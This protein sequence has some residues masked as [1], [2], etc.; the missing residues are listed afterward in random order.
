[1]ST[2]TYSAEQLSRTFFNS[3]ATPAQLNI[4]VALAVLQKFNE[5]QQ[6]V[7]LVNGTTPVL[8]H[9]LNI[10]AAFNHPGV[11]RGLLEI[12]FK[13]IDL[14]VDVN[15]PFNNDPPLMF[16]ALTFRELHLTKVLIMKTDFE[17]L[18]NAKSSWLTYFLNNL[19]TIPGEPVPLTKLLLHADTIVRSKPDG[20]NAFGGID[21]IK[22]L[23]A[24]ATLGGSA[25]PTVKVTELAT[26]SA[27]YN[28][29]LSRLGKEGNTV[30]L[31]DMVLML[32]EITSNVHKVFL[33]RLNMTLCHHDAPLVDDKKASLAIDEELLEVY[34][35]I[36]ARTDTDKV[37]GR[38][39]LHGLCLSGSV[40][41]LDD[42]IEVFSQ[43][44][45]SDERR[46]RTYSQL[47]AALLAKDVR[48][49]TPISYA[50]T[51][52]GPASY[53]GNALNRFC[54]LVGIDYAVY[55]EKIPRFKVS[56]KA[57]A[58]EEE[59][60]DDMPALVEEGS[61]ADKS[62]TVTSS[63]G[64]NTVRMTS[65][66]TTTCDIV[67]VV[68][69][70]VL[71]TNK[72]F[73][74]KYLNTSTPVVFRGATNQKIRDLFVKETFSDAYGDF[75]VPVAPIPYPGKQLVVAVILLIN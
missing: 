20:I 75:V 53:I 36:L 47:A 3:I 48:G 42:L 6:I 72:E 14:G 16:K 37:G 58:S 4:E 19:F 45:L 11:R 35:F 29:L 1:M 71:P 2:P 54:R 59:D 21:G 67:E 61:S 17:A 27:T 56:K 52:W 51:R 8:H 24:G 66:D 5:N 22:R 23:L 69:C 55:V 32:D 70:D 49:H 50:V 25:K 33:N 74:E 26:D 41:V 28:Q 31:I 62:E 39:T 64:W 18:L 13:C 9:L 30:P 44:N 10:F 65:E 73:F 12:V 40:M 60:F 15:A 57:A 38:N 68:D 7:G 34:L 43:I 46:A 63:G